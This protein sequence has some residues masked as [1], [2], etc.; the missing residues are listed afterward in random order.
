MES[1]PDSENSKQNF[2]AI[3]S[4]TRRMQHFAFRIW[5]YVSLFQPPSSNEEFTASLPSTRKSTK[6]ADYVGNV[7][8]QIM[9]SFI[10]ALRSFFE[11]HPNFLRRS[12][13]HLLPSTSSSHQRNPR[14]LNDQLA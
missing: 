14:N 3:P 8:S 5:R 11:I 12:A 4:V 6:T 13:S 10:Q 2:A 9:L 7:D 1:G